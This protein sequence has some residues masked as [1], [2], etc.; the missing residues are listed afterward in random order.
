MIASDDTSNR[1]IQFWVSTDSGT[2]KFLLTSVVVTALSGT[3]TLVNTDVLANS[4]MVGLAVDQSG[5]P[6]LELQASARIYA[7]VIT[8]AVTASKTVWISGFQEDF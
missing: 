6:V 3:A 5:R 4:L 1:T 2:T 7:C 8:A